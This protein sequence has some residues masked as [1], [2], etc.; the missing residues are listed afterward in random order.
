MGDLGSWQ[1]A[2]RLSPA[3][4]QLARVFSEPIWRNKRFHTSCML[5][6][7]DFKSTINNLRDVRIAGIN[8]WGRAR[9]TSDCAN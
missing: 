1:L 6:V 5:L 3:D 9:I 4:M 8:C 2:C 7:T